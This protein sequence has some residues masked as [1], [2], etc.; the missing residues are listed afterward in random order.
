MKEVVDKY[1][2][3]DPAGNVMK[4]VPDTQD[5]YVVEPTTK[6]LNKSVLELNTF[7]NEI[8][9]STLF[10]C[11]NIE[12]KDLFTIDKSEINDLKMAYELSLDYDETI[13]SAFIHSFVSR[14]NTSYV[15]KT[16]VVFNVDEDD[17][18]F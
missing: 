9:P 12:I 6:L 15:A 7:E 17:L 18:P 4:Y 3:R 11:V 13:M 10:K 1:T 14:F 8:S 5:I 16:K 2:W